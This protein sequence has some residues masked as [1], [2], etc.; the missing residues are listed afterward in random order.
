M[1]DQSGADDGGGQLISV[2]PEWIEDRVASV[3]HTVQCLLQ[4]ETL[5]LDCV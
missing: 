3:S 4:K 2:D 1:V 5:Y